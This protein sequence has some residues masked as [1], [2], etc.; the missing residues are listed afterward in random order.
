MR[1]DQLRA[2]LLQVLAAAQRPMTTT[3]ARIAITDTLAGR[4]RPIVSEQVYRALVILQRHGAVRRVEEPSSRAAHWE[5]AML[6]CEIPGA[7]RGYRQQPPPAG[8]GK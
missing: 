8:A 4:G 5:L 6:F 2:E 7:L 1:A 3:E